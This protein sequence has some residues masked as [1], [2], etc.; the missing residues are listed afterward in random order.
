MKSALTII[1]ILLSY[2][3]FSQNNKNFKDFK[4]GTFVYKGK[5]DEVKIIRTKKTQTEIYNDGAS[6]LILDIK[7]IDDSNFELKMKKIVNAPGCLKLGDWIKV[8]IISR[9]DN[10]FNCEYSSERCGSGKS[11]FV[12]IED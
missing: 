3:A 1:F 7:W 9:K 6:K 12:K 4:T 11:V 5:E 8:K 2:L 10:E